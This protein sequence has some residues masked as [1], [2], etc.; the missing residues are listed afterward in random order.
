MVVTLAPIAQRPR[1]NNTERA[2]SVRLFTT[3]KIKMWQ[4]AGMLG[5]R[6]FKYVSEDQKGGGDRRTL[7]MFLFSQIMPTRVKINDSRYIIETTA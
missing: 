7:G 6:Y 4:R 1:T 5:P 3:D 2:N